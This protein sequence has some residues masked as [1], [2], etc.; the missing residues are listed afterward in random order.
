MFTRYCKVVC[1]LSGETINDFISF[2]S[3][4]TATQCP[5]WRNEGLQQEAL[6]IPSSSDMTWADYEKSVRMCDFP[7]KH[8]LIET[9]TK[10]EASGTSECFYV[11]HKLLTELDW[12]IDY[13]DDSLGYCCSTTYLRCLNVHKNIIHHPESHSI[14]TL[15]LTCCW[16]VRLLVSISWREIRVC[17][18]IQMMKEI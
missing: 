9:F 17:V 5:S 10:M 12:L 18:W 13:L 6:G 1:C 7:S 16:P 8:S 3:A 2:Y 11:Q 14:A 15:V 4:A